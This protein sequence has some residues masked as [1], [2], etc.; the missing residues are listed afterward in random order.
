MHMSAYSIAKRRGN[1]KSEPGHG[2]G[3]F[4]KGRGSGPL[5]YPT[6]EIRTI[7]Y[8][9]YLLNGRK[10]RFSG[11]FENFCAKWIGVEKNGQKLCRMPVIF[12]SFPVRQSSAFLRYHTSPAGK[13][14]KS[15]YNSDCCSYEKLCK[16]EITR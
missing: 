8:Q 14:V 11:F 16:D 6:G 13:R 5:T 7:N 12:C 4:R 3:F 2:A 9:K 10:C 15:I 1:Y